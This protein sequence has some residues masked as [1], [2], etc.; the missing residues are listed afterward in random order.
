MPSHRASAISVPPGRKDLHQEVGTVA[1]RVL[2][3]LFHVSSLAAPGSGR[4]S[5]PGYR[6]TSEAEAANVA[7]TPGCGARAPPKYC[8]SQASACALP[9]S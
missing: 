1:A 5:M 8:M 6:V 9:A 2:E 7:G 3:E 4:V